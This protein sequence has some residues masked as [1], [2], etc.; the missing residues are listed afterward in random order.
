MCYNVST[1]YKVM[2]LFPVHLLKVYD[3]LMLCLLSYVLKRILF[4]TFLALC[5]YDAGVSVLRHR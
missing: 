1:H 4:H 5:S 3:F 2:N